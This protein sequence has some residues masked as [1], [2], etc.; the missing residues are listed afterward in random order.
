[1]RLDDVSI[2]QMI[3]EPMRIPPGDQAVD[4]MMERLGT[5]FPFFVPYTHAF[6]DKL[7]PTYT[8]GDWDFYTAGPGGMYM[9]PNLQSTYTLV[10][11]N[12]FTENVTAQ[13][14]GIVASLYSLS[15]VCAKFQDESLSDAFLNLRTWAS[16]HPE[17]EAIFNL[18]D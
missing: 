7:C 11:E 17:R 4:A 3:N 5:N 6:M 15:H 16:A 18:I 13:A 9:A 10:S 8:G 1:M 12:G 2:Q 14:A